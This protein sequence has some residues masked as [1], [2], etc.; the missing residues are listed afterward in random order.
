MFKSN[1]I[2]ISQNIIIKNYQVM[3]KFGANI[4]LHYTRYK[5]GNAKKKVFH[6]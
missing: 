5:E 1:D 3:Q 4:E 6:A 2:E